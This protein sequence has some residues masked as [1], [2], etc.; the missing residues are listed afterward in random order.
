MVS[1]RTRSRYGLRVVRMGEAANPGT[2]GFHTRANSK[3]ERRTIW[4]SQENPT[5]EMW[6]EIESL[7]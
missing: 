7:R 6:T 2:S 4:E 3:R 1:I 5:P